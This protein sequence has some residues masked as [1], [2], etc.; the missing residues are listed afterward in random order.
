M[1]LRPPQGAWCGGKG[2]VAH[3]QHVWRSG[4]VNPV[5]LAIGLVLSML[6]LWSFAS[7]VNFY[8]APRPDGT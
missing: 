7:P 4:E 6:L 8:H 3:A 2:V 5:Y 1:S